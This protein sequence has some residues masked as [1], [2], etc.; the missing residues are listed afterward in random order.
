MAN[1]EAQKE[2]F[3]QFNIVK[4]AKIVKEKSKWCVKAES[5]RNMGCYNTKEEAKERLQQIEYFKHKKGMIEKLI[6]LADKLDKNGFFKKADIVN[7]III[8]IRN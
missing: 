2:A 6:L 4:T 8:K 7:D 1:N 5:G 3:N